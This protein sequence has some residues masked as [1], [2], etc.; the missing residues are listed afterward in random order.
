MAIVPSVSPENEVVQAEPVMEVKPRRNLWVWTAVPGWA[1][2]LI[3]HLAL[4]MILAAIS[5]EPVQKALA[6][7]TVSS[8]GAATEQMQSFDISDAPAPEM[9]E[10]TE[11][12]V[13]LPAAATVTPRL[14]PRRPPCRSG[15]RGE[16]R[17]HACR[18]GDR[19]G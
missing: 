17:G 11:E 14:H 18:G 1:V 19:R 8:N 9:S 13:S 10:P 12:P 4:L 7:L 5:L 15:S 6:I 16:S 3:V 2:S